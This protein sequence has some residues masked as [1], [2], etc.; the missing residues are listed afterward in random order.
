MDFEI[1]TFEMERKVSF[2]LCL[3]GIAD[4]DRLWCKNSE[5]RNF[6]LLHHR[7]VHHFRYMCTKS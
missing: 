6:E 4:F 5:L 1:I 2:T 7:N 3:V